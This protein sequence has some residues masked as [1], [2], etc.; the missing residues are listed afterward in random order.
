MCYRSTEVWRLMGGV[1][2]ASGGSGSWDQFHR[3][4][5]LGKRSQRGRGQDSMRWKISTT[6]RKDLYISLYVKI[7]VL[8]NSA[9]LQN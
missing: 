9:L 8:I 7:Y 4:G 5:I 1:V 2:R 6:L 3:K